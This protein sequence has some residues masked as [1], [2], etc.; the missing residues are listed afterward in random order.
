MFL[1]YEDAQLMAS[2]PDSIYFKDVQGKLERM[3]GDAVR[4][5]LPF[6]PSMSIVKDSGFFTTRGHVIYEIRNRILSGSTYRLTVNIGGLKD[7]ATASTTP[8][9]NLKV[10]SWNGWPGT[11]INMTNES[12][13]NVIWKKLPGIN[14]YRLSYLFR[15]YEISDQDTIERQIVWKVPDK[16]YSSSSTGEEIIYQVPINQWFL[17]LGD[18]IPDR[19]LV[20]RRI[21]GSF[22]LQWEFQR[23][24][25]EDFY[26]RNQLSGKEMWLDYVLYSNI[27]NAVGIFSFQSRFVIPMVDISLYTLEKITT[28]PATKDLKFDAR[29]TW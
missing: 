27:T 18:Q 25:L 13:A 16:I 20:K 15:Y 17:Y 3:E 7:T 24:E 4:E 19:P 12:F 14:S 21:A 9:T 28:H 26:D 2:Q 8:L 5:T 22:D 11:S 6:Y 23:T 1:G 29:V 10:I